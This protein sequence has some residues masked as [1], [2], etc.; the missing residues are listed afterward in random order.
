MNSLSPAG[1][2]ESPFRKCCGIR[3]QP[4]EFLRLLGAHNFPIVFANHRRRCPRNLGRFILV[5]K[6]RNMI[7]DEA[8]AKRV[9]WPVVPQSGRLAHFGED[10]PPVG[11]NGLV[12]MGGIA[13]AQWCTDRQRSSG[14]D[15]R[16]AGQKASSDSHCIDLICAVDKQ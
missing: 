13:S 15:G 1:R 12:V 11:G 9:L 8:V 10:V 14:Q 5:P 6:P 16:G 7:A 3:E 4:E 2:H